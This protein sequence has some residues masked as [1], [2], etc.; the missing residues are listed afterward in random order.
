MDL[1]VASSARRFI[2]VNPSLWLQFRTKHLP[3]HKTFKERRLTIKEAATSMGVF[4]WLINGFIYTILFLIKPLYSTLSYFIT[5]LIS[6]NC[7]ASA[8]YMLFLMTRIF[9]DR[10]ANANNN[11]FAT[12][13]FSLQNG[14]LFSTVF[15]ITFLIVSLILISK[16]MEDTQLLMGIPFGYIIIPA[17]L[18]LPVLYVFG[19]Y[20]WVCRKKHS[21]WSSVFLTGSIFL[22]TPILYILHKL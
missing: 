12:G 14:F 5:S 1:H 9:S 6:L 21:Y 20:R 19:I 8:F 2:L 13:H 16:D 15:F 18:F 10:K 17:K 4:L 11:S 22:I 3:I 7:L